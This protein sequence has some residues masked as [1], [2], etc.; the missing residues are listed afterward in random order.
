MLEKLTATTTA[1]KA[2]ATTMA[3]Q[4]KR[5]S[6]EEAGRSADMANAARRHVFPE[7]DRPYT[8]TL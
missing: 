7:D 8:P 2:Q 4:E 3:R 5:S 1:A 6:Q